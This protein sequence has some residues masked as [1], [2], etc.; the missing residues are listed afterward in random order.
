MSAIKKVNSAT[1]Y[2]LQKLI[3]RISGAVP[4]LDVFASE[5]LNKSTFLEIK[6]RSNTRLSYLMEIRS[7]YF[8]ENDIGQVQFYHF[9]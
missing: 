8:W 4:E 1:I 3:W 7:L 6:G 5:L 2:V 9:N